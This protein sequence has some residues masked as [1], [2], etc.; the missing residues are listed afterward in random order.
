MAIFER[1]R[2]HALVTSSAAVLGWD[3]ETF[4]PSAAARHRA[5]QLAWLSARAHEMAT[6]G[7]W[8]RDLEAAENADAGDDPKLTANLRELRRRFDRATKLP[9]ELVA[10]A[11]AASSLAK[12]A[13]AEARAKSDFPLFAPHLEK[14]L[15]IAREQAELWGYEE[16]PYDA[17]LEEYERGARTREVAG[18]F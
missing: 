1:A 16:E 4:L 14:L 2:E 11:S 12:H 10:R 18:L 13:W 15:G 7:E 9:T 3:Q 5:D 17:L 8:R 6:S